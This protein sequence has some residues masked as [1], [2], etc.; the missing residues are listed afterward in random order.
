MGV[1][2]EYA[3]CSGEPVL[4]QPEDL[5]WNYRQ[6]AAV[7]DVAQHQDAKTIELVLTPSSR[8]T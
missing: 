8:S 5:V 6:F 3:N 2:I 7:G 1:V 4:M